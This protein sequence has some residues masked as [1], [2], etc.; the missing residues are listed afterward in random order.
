[1]QKTFLRFRGFCWALP[2]A[3]VTV[4]AIGCGSGETP[5][6]E[7]AATEEVAPAATEA[8]PVDTTTATVPD[9]TNMPTDTSAGGKPP[10]NR[11]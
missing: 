9:T 6:E 8:A 4:M 11:K 10:V 5:A 3:L 1:M 7:P 2:L